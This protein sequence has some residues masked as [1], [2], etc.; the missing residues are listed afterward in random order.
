MKDNTQFIKTLQ[1]LPQFDRLLE[2]TQQEWEKAGR[3]TDARPYPWESEIARGNANFYASRDPFEEM[4]SYGSR[5]T[6][7]G[8]FNGKI[9]DGYI[10]LAS[11]SLYELYDMAGNVWQNGLGKDGFL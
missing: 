10:N 3:G 4:S 9:Y 6:P 7:V 2:E 11:P 1:H 8:F 5:T